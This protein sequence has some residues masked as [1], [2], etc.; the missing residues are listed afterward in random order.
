MED[1]FRTQEMLGV[2]KG[3][4]YVWGPIKN[5]LIGDYMERTF[6][7]GKQETQFPIKLTL[8]RKLLRSMVV[9]GNGRSRRVLTL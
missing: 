7:L 5:T 6:H 1:G 2:L 4:F 8:P 3:G 9:W